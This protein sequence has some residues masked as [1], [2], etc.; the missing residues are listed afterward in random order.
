MLLKKL[1]RDLEGMSQK[2]D[3]FPDAIEGPTNAI[4]LRRDGNILRSRLK[5]LF[6]FLVIDVSVSFSAPRSWAR[7][8]KSSA[9][10]GV[11]I[12]NGAARERELEA[13]DR[14]TGIQRGQ[15]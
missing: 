6:D 14:F 3:S 5:F 4:A 13:V 8:K 7:L 9:E 10:F 2:S 1:K 12:E 15:K 11:G